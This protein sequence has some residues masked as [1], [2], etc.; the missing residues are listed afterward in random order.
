MTVIMY[1]VRAAEDDALPRLPHYIAI[2]C[3]LRTPIGD[4]CTLIL[5]YDSGMVDVNLLSY[6]K[7][8]L[9]NSD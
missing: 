7:D 5:C 3:C 2:E 9:Y 4:A 6:Q 1:V 8:Y